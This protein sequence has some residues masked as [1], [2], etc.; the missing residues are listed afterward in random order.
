MHK[1]TRTR[2]HNLVCLSEMKFQLTD[3]PIL[4]MEGKQ[5]HRKKCMPLGTFLNQ[6]Y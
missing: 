2:E 3:F 6:Q 1:T 5:M 4:Y